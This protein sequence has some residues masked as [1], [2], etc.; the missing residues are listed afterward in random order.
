VG[1]SLSLI[2]P[3]YRDDTLSRKLETL[4]T[5][6]LA[7]P[8]FEVLVVV[9][10]RELAGLKSLQQVWPFVVR[11][12]IIANEDAEG[13]YIIA[14]KR[15]RGVLAAVTPLYMFT[16]DDVLHPP[17]SLEVFHSYYAAGFRGLAT[18]D[19]RFEDG[20][21]FRVSRNASVPWNRLNGSLLVIDASTFQ[22][23]GAFNEGIR[24]RGGEDIE[25]A[26]RAK[27]QGILLRRL[28]GDYAVHVGEP[29]TDF[30]TGRTCGY[31][32]YTTS[33]RYAADYAFALG[34]HPLSLRLKRLAFRLGIGTTSR[35]AAY[36]QGY[37]QGALEA[38][39]ETQ[40]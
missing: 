30:E 34:V 3:A 1:L 23:V 33:Q 22:N 8:S 35:Y 14:L 29:R 27:Q 11:P 37:L 16:D 19:L 4:T 9:L 13:V 2:V 31:Q 5:Q 21:L 17:K 36:E 28:E 6:T 25:Y 12:V 7:A 32:A 38:K 40:T 39:R 20:T 26:Y 10:E 24:G 18:C 15:N